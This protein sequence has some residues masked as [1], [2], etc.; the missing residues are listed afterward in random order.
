MTKRASGNLRVKHGQ[1]PDESKSPH[2]DSGAVWEKSL[3][4]TIGSDLSA[5]R[6]VRDL[7]LKEVDHF[8]FDRQSHF[9]IQLALEEAI[10][11]AIKHGNSHDPNKKVE[12][13]FK[14]NAKQLDVWIEDEGPGFK[15]DAVPDPTLDENIEKCS[16]RGILLIEAYMSSVK[17]TRE[18]R[19]L[20]MIKKN[21]QDSTV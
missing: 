16:G 21:D 1:A 7:V 10:I 14:I 11:N 13:E 20:H 4:L 3:K 8:G 17:W 12:I 6:E 9:A 2:P 5:V 15:R 18:G 19:R